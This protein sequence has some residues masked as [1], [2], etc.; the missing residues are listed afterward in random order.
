MTVSYWTL[1]WQTMHVAGKYAHYNWKVNPQQMQ[2]TKEQAPLSLTTRQRQLHVRHHT[3]STIYV[4]RT[5]EGSP[6]WVH[7]LC[8]TVQHCRGHQKL[9]RCRAES[10]R[11]ENQRKW[12]GQKTAK[13]NNRCDRIQTFVRKSKTKTKKF[14]EGSVTKWEFP[15]SNSK[16]F[17]IL[18]KLY[19]FS[20][21][22]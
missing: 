1:C 18:S 5:G 6:Q 13:R 12:K 9:P 11:N 20:N 16:Q 14:L 8:S 4:Q 21:L 22:I 19:G 10:L 2:R 7:P 15:D 17:K 3:K